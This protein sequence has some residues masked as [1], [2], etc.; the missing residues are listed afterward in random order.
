MLKIL[1]PVVLIIIGIGFAEP[2]AYRELY[3]EQNALSARALALGKTG[4]AVNQNN[5]DA[6]FINPATISTRNNLSV[7][8]E[9]TLVDVHR[10]MIQGTFSVAAPQASMPK[11]TPSVSESMLVT[12]TVT[13]NIAPTENSIPTA[14][15]TASETLAAAVNNDVLTAEPVE[16]SSVALGYSNSSISDIPI[17]ELSG[18]ELLVADIAGYTE[19]V[20]LLGY[21]RS[22]QPGLRAGITGKY[23]NN[24]LKIEQRLYDRGNASGGDVDLGLFWQAQEFDLGLGYRNV[25]SAISTRGVLK[26]DTG[27]ESSFDNGFFTGLHKKY[28]D[29]IDVNFDIFNSRLH[30]MIYGIGMEYKIVSE[31]KLRLGYNSSQKFSTGLGL[32]LNEQ[33]II[34]YAFLPDFG[35]GIDS[36]HFFSLSYIF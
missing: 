15:V 24:A 33:F 19:Q 32:A 7:K 31:C 4:A 6:L 36:K 8:S 11:I 9:S 30:K 17:A 13:E 20:T 5:Y 27:V 28:S 25:L 10:F 3:L 21:A 1:L 23:Y 34:D 22:I 18:T 16:D 14:T 35:T 29:G 26:W 2:E 12:A